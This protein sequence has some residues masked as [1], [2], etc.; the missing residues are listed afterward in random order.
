[1]SRDAGGGRSAPTSTIADIDANLERCERLSPP[2]SPGAD[3]IVLP[4]FFT[5][6][7]GFDARLADTALAPD[8]AATTF[9]PAWPRRHGATVGGSFLCRDPDGHVR[10]ALMLIGPDGS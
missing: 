4:E 2:R 1:M 3:W 7:I 9:S 10:N 8:G 5:T 6:G